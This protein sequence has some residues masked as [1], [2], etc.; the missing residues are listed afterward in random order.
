MTRPTIRYISPNGSLNGVVPT[1]LSL[2][3]TGLSPERAVTT[4]P[5]TGGVAQTSGRARIL[6][7]GIQR[8]SPR[9]A[10]RLDHDTDAG[11][12]DRNRVDVAP[13]LPTQRMAQPPTLRLQRRE[14]ALHLTL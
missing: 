10:F 1:A 12:G 4:A 6:E 2:S 14:R 13:T 9:G 7:P 8:G 5:P 11:R 3:G